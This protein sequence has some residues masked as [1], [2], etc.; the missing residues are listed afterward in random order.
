MPCESWPRRFDSTRLTATSFA[1]ADST[2]DATNR[3]VENRTSSASSRPAKHH[4]MSK[5]GIVLKF[6]TTVTESL[7]VKSHARTNMT[8]V[9]PRGLVV[10]TRRIRAARSGF[11]CR[12]NQQLLNCHKLP[13][14]RFVIGIL[15]Q[16]G[17]QKWKRQFRASEISIS[18]C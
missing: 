5:N 2:P 7:A 12:F 8:W 15:V 17:F 4:L 9:C 3:A 11:H 16:G 18:V 10:L 13:P 14:G 1:S 6:P